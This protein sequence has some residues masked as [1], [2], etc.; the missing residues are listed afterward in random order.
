MK[1]LTIDKELNKI[2]TTQ[3]VITLHSIFI[4][5]FLEMIL[6]NMMGTVSTIMLGHYSDNAVAAVGSASQFMGMI[7]TFYTV[8]SSGAS[9]I[10]SHN[11]GAN[12]KKVASDAAF[13]TIIFSFV[14]SFSIGILLSIFSLPLMA[15]MQIKD[16]L[17]LD[18]STYFSIC[19]LFSGIQAIISS[20]SA[21]LRSYGKPKIAVLVSLFM[22]IINAILDFII[23]YRPFETPLHGVSG[24]ATSYVISQF[25]ALILIVILFINAPL[26][27]Q[28]N[29]KSFRSLKIIKDILYIGVPGGISSLSYSMSQVVSTSIIAV[30]GVTAISTKIYLSNIFFYVYVVGLSLGLATSLMVGWLVGAGKYEQAYR[31]N[32]QNLKITIL[33][34]ILIS[35]LILL[36]GNKIINLFTS[37]PEIIAMSKIIMI[38]DLFVEIGRGFNHIEGNSLRG[39]GDVIFQMVISIISCWSMSILFS[40][41][42]AIKLGLGLPG[43]W[44]SFAMDEIFRGIIFF[45]R[46]KSR[47]WTKKSLV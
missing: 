15:L 27:L 22:N 24:I 36:L 28:F 35:L 20:L 16:A 2:E 42:L 46:W 33:L 13:T 21:I 29:K 7:F 37:N 34:N 45:F 38:I 14:L 3:G 30:L 19:I 39:A 4:A 25:C 11:L 9:I 6:T 47:K 26:D 8:I 32:N 41:I 1:L 23:I 44:I 12:K 40:Y 5:F 18:A 43:C 10:I 31:L 17:L